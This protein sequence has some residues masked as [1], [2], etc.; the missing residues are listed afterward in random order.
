MRFQHEGNL[1]C[2]LAFELEAKKYGKS[3]YFQSEVSKPIRL[4]PV[5]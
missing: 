1:K 2:D 5:K 3:F 4:K